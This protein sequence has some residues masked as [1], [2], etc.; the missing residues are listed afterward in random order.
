MFACRW[1]VVKNYCVA[2]DVSKKTLLKFEEGS[3]NSPKK[4][5]PRPIGRLKPSVGKKEN[6]SL[7]NYEKL[8]KVD[9][10]CDIEDLISSDEPRFPGL[11]DVFELMNVEKIRY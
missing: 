2:I 5:N 4:G 3:Q 8:M 1:C 11:D 10:L 6:V 9:Q 7:R